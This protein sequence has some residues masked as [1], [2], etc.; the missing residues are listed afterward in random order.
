MIV[1]LSLLPE[2]ILY[3]EHI[4]KKILFRRKVE[5]KLVSVFEKIK[6]ADYYFKDFKDILELI[7]MRNL[8]KTETIWWRVKSA[9]AMRYYGI[10]QENE[11]CGVT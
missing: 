1:S 6:E 10:R 2:E 3:I 4:S 7:K 9:V 8:F 11:D 5:L